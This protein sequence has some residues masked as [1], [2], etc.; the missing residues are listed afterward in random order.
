MGRWYPTENHSLEI[1]R[2]RDGRIATEDRIDLLVRE[3][4]AHPGAY[5]DQVLPGP[6]TCWLRGNKRFPNH[7]LF[8]VVGK[9]DSASRGL[10]E[11]PGFDFGLKV[12]SNCHERGSFRVSTTL[13]RLPIRRGHSQVWQ[14]RAGT[15]RPPSQ[16]RHLLSDS[17]SRAHQPLLQ[18]RQ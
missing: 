9:R 13:L 4:T 2:T 16:L 3:Q 15:P 8:H 5:I 6:G 7:D 12:E 18:N 10:C 1:N 11:K 14:R 17:V